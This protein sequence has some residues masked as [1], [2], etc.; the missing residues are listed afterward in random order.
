MVE[1]YSIAVAGN[2]GVGKSSLTRMLADE[3]GWTP[4]YEAVDDNP[5]L[6]DFYTDMP[7]WSFHSQLFFLSRRLRYHRQ[8]ANHPNHVV[9]DRSVYEDAGIFARNLFH[10]KNMTPRDYQL[11]RDLYEEFIQIVPPPKL[12]VYLKASIPTLIERIHRRGR[13][14]EQDISPL[15]LQQL[16][17]LYREWSEDFTLCPIL[18]IETDLLDFVRFSDDFY[19]I[20]DQIL[21]ALGLREKVLVRHV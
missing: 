18:T 4:F 20:K 5:Y 10:R 21:N 9:Q 17:E 13:D 3:L 6:A 15:Y 7:R 19:V 11:Y 14:F 8:I 1:K 2:M 12:I 16:N